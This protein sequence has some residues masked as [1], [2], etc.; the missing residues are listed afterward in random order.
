MP[1]NNILFE[2][3]DRR[4]RESTS[5]NHLIWG[6]TTGLLLGTAV[7]ILVFDSVGAGIG[8]GIVVGALLAII[9]RPRRT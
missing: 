4:N 8:V 1:D 5:S 7:G 3:E 6:M 2:E 9:F